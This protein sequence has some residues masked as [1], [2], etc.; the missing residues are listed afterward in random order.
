M[1]VT[2][3]ANGLAPAAPQIAKLMGPETGAGHRHQRHS[4]LVFLWPGWSLARP[5]GGKRRSRRQAVADAAAA[6]GDRL[7]RLSR[8]RSDRAGRDRAHLWQPLHPGRTGRQQKRAR[9]SPVANA[10][11]GRAESAGAHQYPRR[12]LGEAVGQSGLQS[13]V[14]ADRLD[15]GPSRLPPRSA[16]GGPRH[17]GGSRRRWPRRWA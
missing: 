17:D 8:R 1:V 9:R 14:G 10:G 7:H 11:E 13:A 4:L 2:L 5:G 12:D 6:P 16:R 3:K 15:P